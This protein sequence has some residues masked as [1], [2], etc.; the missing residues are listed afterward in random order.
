EC[1]PGEGAISSD[2]MFED[3]R[4]GDYHLTEGSPCIDAGNPDSARD[5]NGTRA[6]IGA[7]YFDYPNSI[8]DEFAP[9]NVENYELTGVYPNPFNSTAVIGYYLPE[10]SNVKIKLFDLMGRLQMKL[11]DRECNGGTHKI[12]W[13]PKSQS[14]GMYLVQMQ[15]GE[16]SSIRKVM[17]LP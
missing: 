9:T 17:L 16:F 10:R 11:V 2:P 1:T 5:P 14:A 13:S 6:D 15:A 8:W 7:F 4:S 3:L 12:E